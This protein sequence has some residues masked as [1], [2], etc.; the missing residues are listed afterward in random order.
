MTR[1]A[2]II[3]G[4]ALTILVAVWASA[5]TLCVT[6]DITIKDPIMTP[7]GGTDVGVIARKQESIEPTS[8]V[9]PLVPASSQVS[10]SAGD[11][12]VAKHDLGDADISVFPASLTERPPQI[13]AGEPPA[14]MPISQPADRQLRSPHR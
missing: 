10:L 7:T 13:V 5:C 11:P 1:T 12:S 9:A 4:L 14:K 2:K 8:Y 6:A 3:T